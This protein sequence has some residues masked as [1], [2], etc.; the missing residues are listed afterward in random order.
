MKIYCPK[1]GS[2][3]DTEA[4]PAH[5]GDEPEFAFCPNQEC[6]EVINLKYDQYRR[7]DEKPSCPHPL[8]LTASPHKAEFEQ[9]TFSLT[10]ILP[11]ASAY[12]TIEFPFSTSQTFDFAVK[13]ASKHPSF[14]QSGKGKKVIYRVTY[15]PSEMATAIE[16]VE[17]LKGWRNR[18]VYVGGEKV[19]WDSVFS[20]TWCFQRKHGCF[21]P[22]FYCFG[23]EREWEFNIWGCLLSGLPFREPAEWFCWGRFLNNKGDWQF[24]KERIRHELQKNLY[25]YR[26][27]PAL[28]L[29]R[30]HEVFNAF[31]AQV[32]PTKDK[33][34]KYVESW[35]NESG[36]GL[37]VS[38]T[39]HGFT[40]KVVMKGVCPKGR[41]VL[42]EIGKRM[43]IQFPLTDEK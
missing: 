18:R 9:K 28:N 13:E 31:P 14:E 23:Y 8:T 11:I 26:F 32:N 38:V 3:V 7:V 37:V 40:E 42:L 12:I 43:G 19:P 29:E 10:E 33:D 16:L 41:G 27:C 4:D 25:P 39:R 17:H 22:E 2:V 35:G 20:F 24:D 30:L 6:L 21:R 34:W 36:S 5:I 1:C 15:S